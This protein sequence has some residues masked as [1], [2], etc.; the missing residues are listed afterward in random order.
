MARISGLRNLGVSGGAIGIAVAAAV[1]LVVV[2]LIART[3]CEPAAEPEK[4]AT[5]SAGGTTPVLPDREQAVVAPPKLE[6]PP[7]PDRSA[8]VYEQYRLAGQQALDR[9]DYVR[10]REQLSLA[11]KGL[12]DPLKLKSVKVQLAD[13]AEKLTFSS[14]VYSDDKTAELYHVEAGDLPSTVGKKFGITAEFFMTINRIADDRSMR[15]NRNYKVIQGPFSV[16]IRKK[17][18]ELDVFLGKNFIKSYRIGLGRDGSTPVGEFL[19]GPKLPNPEW[20]GEDTSGRRIRVPYGDPNNPLGTRWITL[21]HL[22]QNG[23]S[24]TDYGIHGTNDPTSIGTEASRGCI[25]M[26]NKD[27]EEL[28]NLLVIGKSPIT[29][30]D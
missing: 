27:V 18:F 20:W 16:V 9:G 23:G 24:K 10:A 11:V 14:R 19:A 6:Q 21:K 29:V 1:L 12:S 25:R 26:R 28:Y 15:A 5:E 3:G 13:I 8:T 4:P 22:P 17:D 30:L 2:I 7:A